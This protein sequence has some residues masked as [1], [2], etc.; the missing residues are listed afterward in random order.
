MRGFYIP[1]F[2][3]HLP[4]SYH[5]PT[6]DEEEEVTVLPAITTIEND[7]IKDILKKHHSVNKTCRVF[8]WVLTF[9]MRITQNNPAFV[10]G[11]GGIGEHI[12]HLYKA[13]SD[14]TSPCLIT[15]QHSE[16]WTYMEGTHGTLIPVFKNIDHEMSRLILI[17][18]DQRQHFGSLLDNIKNEGKLPE[19]IEKLRPYYD[20]SHKVVRIQG[21]LRDADGMGASC[22]ILLHK[23]SNFAKK[24][25]YFWHTLNFC[26]GIKYITYHTR[27]SYHIMSIWTVIN[28]VIDKCPNP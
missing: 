20:S 22:Q 23:D 24:L 10:N 25:V 27:L 16:E 9:I 2:D 6:K 19:K 17:H 11:N 7:T 1:N 18:F 3:H 13:L 15:N 5:E 21:R 4:V 8:S 28:K 12:Y 14:G 26:T